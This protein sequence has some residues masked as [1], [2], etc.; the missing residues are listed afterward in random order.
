[1][2]I[3]CWN[4]ECE[5]QRGEYFCKA[6]FNAIG[7][8]D[9]KRPVKD[10]NE[11]VAEVPCSAGLCTLLREALTI[12]DEGGNEVPEGSTALWNAEWEALR[13]KIFKAYEIVNQEGV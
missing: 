3:H 13:S 2:D 7:C 11:P 6:P 4:K 5:H 8:E 10:D 9:H 12:M 1:M